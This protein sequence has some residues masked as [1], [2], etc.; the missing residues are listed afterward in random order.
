MRGWLLMRRREVLRASAWLLGTMA[1]ASVSRAL[2]ADELP[3]SS[4]G[5]FADQE[6]A[7]IDLLAD[8]IIPPTD[9]PGAVDAGVSDV[10]ATIFRDWYTDNE[11]GSFL[12]GLAALDDYCLDKSGSA[13]RHASDAVRIAALREQEAR[14]SSTPPPA[15][16]PFGA[17]SAGENAPFFTRLKEL[18][19]L[20]YY[21]SKIGATQE[22]AYVPAPGRFDGAYEFAKVG[23][24]WSR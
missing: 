8:M 2:L 5:A 3:L 22:L 18:V 20:G 10:V 21:T 6:K 9:T 4:D 19:V 15:P 17:R 12:Q 13:F 7:A 14:A 16:G 24:Q 11:R 23:R 1:S